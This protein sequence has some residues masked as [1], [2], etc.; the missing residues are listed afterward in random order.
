LSKLY[1]PSIGR[2]P[3]LFCK[4][5][6]TSICFKREDDLNSIFEMEDY[7]KFIFKREDNL[8]LF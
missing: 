2:R 4:W 1:E 6:T 8:K 7:L 3:P 5:K